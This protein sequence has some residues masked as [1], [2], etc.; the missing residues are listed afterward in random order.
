MMSYS[1]LIKYSFFST[2]SFFFIS[3]SGPEKLDLSNIESEV[4]TFYENDTEE[5]NFPSMMISTNGQQIVDEPKINADLAVI[6]LL[7]TSPSPRD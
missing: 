1:N 3:C 2:L 4:I 5:N 6:C 7:Y